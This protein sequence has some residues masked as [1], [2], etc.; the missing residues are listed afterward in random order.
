VNQELADDHC[1][2]CGFDSSTRGREDFIV[3]LEDAGGLIDAALADASHRDLNLRPNT[4]TWSKLEYVEH[5]R[6]VFLHSGLI[7]EQVALEPDKTYEGDFPPGIEPK[8]AMLDRN[9]ITAAQ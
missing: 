1:D 3:L 6:E 8:P 2:A 5:L 4:E 9:D 7:C